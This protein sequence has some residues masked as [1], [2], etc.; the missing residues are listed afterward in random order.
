[1]SRNGWREGIHIMVKRTAVEPDK[2]YFFTTKT[3]SSM[4]AMIT[5]AHRKPR[6]TSLNA[7]VFIAYLKQSAR[8][9]AT[10]CLRSNEH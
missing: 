1:M 8:T 3:S 6:M 5:Y 7:E 2:D 4:E 9:N 10:W